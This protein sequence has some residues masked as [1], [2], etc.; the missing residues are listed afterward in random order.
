MRLVFTSLEAQ[1]RRPSFGL[2][3]SAGARSID[4]E[5]EVKKFVASGHNF[6]PRVVFDFFTSNRATLCR[7]AAHYCGSCRR[8]HDTLARDLRSKLWQR[9]PTVPIMHL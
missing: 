9:W 8:L 6:L 1:Y 3:Q 5:P 2:G 7:Q 4:L